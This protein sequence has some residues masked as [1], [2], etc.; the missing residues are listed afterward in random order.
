MKTSSPEA[1]SLEEELPEPFDEEPLPPED[2][3]LPDD[4]PAPFWTTWIVMLLE[5]MV[6][7]LTVAVAAGRVNVPVFLGRR[8]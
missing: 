1:A 8:I 6:S 4:W 2:E 3:L 7:P 5:E